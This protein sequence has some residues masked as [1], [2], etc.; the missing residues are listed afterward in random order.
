VRLNPARV[1]GGSFCLKKLPL[2]YH[3]DICTYIGICNVPICD[4]NYQRLITYICTVILYYLGKIK[5]S[6]LRFLSKSEMSNDK[7]SNYKML[8]DKMS[9]DKMSTDKMST[10]KM[11]KPPI[12]T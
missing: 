2:N 5:F 8:N 10:D 6:L 4:S 3:R 12:L 9:T 11:S 7:M 1:Y